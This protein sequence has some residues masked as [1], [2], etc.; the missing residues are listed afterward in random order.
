MFKNGH[1]VT[2]CTNIHPGESWEAT[3]QNLKEYIPRIKAAVSPNAAFG[4][5]LRSSHE[6]SLELAKMENLD[7]FKAWLAANDCY[8]FTFN[9]FPYGGFHNQVVKDEVHQPDWTTAER[10][11]YTDRLFDILEELL[12]KG[13]DFFVGSAKFS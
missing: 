5:G 13:M 12:P 8:V 7:E 3:F 11:A 10:L 9:G 1:H 2:Y 4:I 6:A